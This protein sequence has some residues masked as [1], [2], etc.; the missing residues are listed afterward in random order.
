MNTYSP[1]SQPLTLLVVEI[2]PDKTVAVVSLAVKGTGTDAASNRSLEV[3]RSEVVPATVGR[4]AG[5]E[6]GW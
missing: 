1:S 4:L 5:A 3:L 6:V 2:S